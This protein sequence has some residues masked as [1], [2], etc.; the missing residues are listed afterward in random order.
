MLWNR[1]FYV[2]DT[3]IHFSTT[4]FSSLCV[5]S[6]YLGNPCS[7][8]VSP[9]AMYSPRIRVIVLRGGIVVYYHS[10]KWPRTQDPNFSFW[11]CGNMIVPFLWLVFLSLWLIY[12]LSTLPFLFTLLKSRAF[13]VPTRRK[14]D[15]FGKKTW[16]VVDDFQFANFNDPS[17]IP[18][19]E[20]II[21]T[22]SWG[23]RRFVPMFWLYITMFINISLNRGAWQC[24]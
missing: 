7:R 5:I 13:Y 18:C 10:Q 22:K 14:C 24:R 17:Y 15:M 21:I 20:V 16:E 3:S 11:R 2:Q 8:N 4:L 12:R 23:L 9:G 1:K 6:S 19:E